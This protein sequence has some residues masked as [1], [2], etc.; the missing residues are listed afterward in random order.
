MFF[1][2]NQPNMSPGNLAS[3]HFLHGCFVLRLFREN[4]TVIK[5]LNDV[6]H[7]NT[8]ADSKSKVNYSSACF[9]LGLYFNSN[10]NCVLMCNDQFI[11]LSRPVAYNIHK[12]Y[13]KCE[14]LII[15]LSRSNYSVELSSHFHT[16]CVRS[17]KQLKLHLKSHRLNCRL[18]NSAMLSYW[19]NLPFLPKYLAC[20][21]HFSLKMNKKVSRT[22]VTQQTSASR[23]QCSQL[24]TVDF[25]K[26]A[27]SEKIK[28]H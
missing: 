10:K 18:R 20:S 19:A 1:M 16:A 24:D 17:K 12:L 25:D 13:C 7:K 3:F 4:I 28:L 2:F 27:N 22:A 23:S 9:F 26:V 21:V 14:I 5:S 11:F 15:T 6:G 8:S